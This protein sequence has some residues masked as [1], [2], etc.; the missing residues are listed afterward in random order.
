MAI[1]YSLIPLLVQQNYLDAARSGLYRPGTH[2]S[3]SDK[4]DALSCASQAVSDMELLGAGVFGADSHWELLPA[5]AA[6]CVRVGSFVQGFQG[7]PTFPAVHA[8]ILSRANDLLIR[9]LSVC[10]AVAGQ[11]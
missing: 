10:C 6:M 5:Q 8:V 11:E 7:F 4:I 2:L 1:D 9:L 3:D